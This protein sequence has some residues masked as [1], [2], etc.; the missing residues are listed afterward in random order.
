M[1]M[2]KKLPWVTI[3]VAIA[4]ALKFGPDIM[5]FLNEKAPSVGKLVTP[6]DKTAV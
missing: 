2:L 3:I 1:N 4:A 6:T 5:D